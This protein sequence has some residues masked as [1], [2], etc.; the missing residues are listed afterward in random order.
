MSV[1]KDFPDVF[2]EDIP[3]LPPVR[4]IE[5][6]IDLVLGSGPILIAPNRMAPM[7]WLS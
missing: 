2:P 3:G 4:E 1:I 7:N 5:F 6:T